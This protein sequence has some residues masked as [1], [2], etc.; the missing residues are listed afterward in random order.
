MKHL[1]G[2]VG[3]KRSGKDTVGNLLSRYIPGVVLFG[4]GDI[5]RKEIAAHTGGCI[6]LITE[7]K[8]TP[9]GR[10]MQQQWGDFRREQSAG[11]W[12]AQAIN[13]YEHLPDGKMCVFT[14]VRLD[15]EVDAVHKQNGIIVR[16][17]RNQVDGADDS[18]ITENVEHISWDFS[19]HNHDGFGRL[20]WE[21]KCLA[22]H[23]KERFKL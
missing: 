21:V 13:F 2:L 20:N 6:D 9:E 23:I 16:V 12:I 5:I 15:I 4:V 3:K 14:S 18:H 8:D 17:F 1:I 19:V 22:S 10:R 7:N 11:Y